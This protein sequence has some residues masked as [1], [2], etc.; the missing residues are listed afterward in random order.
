MKILFTC[1]GTA[2]HINPAIALARLFQARHQDCQVLFAGADNGMERTLVPHEGY[3]LR[4]VH[5]NTIHRAWKWKDIKHNIMTVVTLPQARRQ[6]RTILD[7]FKPDLVVGTGGY[8]SYPVVKEAA[9]RGIPTAVHESNAV[10]GLTTKLLSKVV[11]RVMVGFEDSRKHYPHPERVV[12]TGTPVR[13]DFFDHT[14]KEARQALGLADDRPLLLSYWGSLGADVMNRY[15][16]DF[17]Q[18][19]AAESFPFHH[20]HGAGRN[21]KSLTAAL[22]ERGVDLT[23]GAEVREYIY[24]M[25]LVMAAADLVVCRAGASTISELTA[26]AKPCV[27][28]PSPNVTNNHQE[29]NARVLEHHG[30]AVVLLEPE[31]DGA[32]L[33]REVKELLADPEK[34]SDMSKAL[35]ELSVTDA[36]E[37]IYQTLMSLMKRGE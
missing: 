32:A 30:A 24:D 23:G 21:Y 10:P 14:R 11:D 4:T 19:E 9:R 15:M 12:V 5:V 34:R 27:L 29:K 35:T 25:P 20:I 8:A 18:A 31:I 7:E 2:G 1:G 26:I 17:F 16:V 22:A 28:V 33:Y 36:A 3:E 37:E 13:R 6:A